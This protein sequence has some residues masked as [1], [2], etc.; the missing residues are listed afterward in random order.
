M[1]GAFALD[2]PDH[3]G[4]RQLGRHAQKHVHVIGQDVHLFDP[5]L[6][7]LGQVLEHGIKLPAHHAKEHSSSVLGY[8]DD[9]GFALPFGVTQTAVFFHGCCGW[10]A[11]VG[12]QL[13]PHGRAAGKVKLREPPRQSRGNSY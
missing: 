4:N 3:A 12:S 7:L 8:K 9:V 1:D 2:E 11:L 10:C 6:L 5:T 13:T